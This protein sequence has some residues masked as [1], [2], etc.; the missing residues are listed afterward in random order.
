MRVIRD[1][2]L[3]FNYILRVD[4]FPD[5]RIRL[6]LAARPT[7]AGFLRLR[8]DRDYVSCLHSGLRIGPGRAGYANAM[9]HSPTPQTTQRPIVREIDVAAFPRARLKLQ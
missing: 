7:S 1:C 4:I 5:L 9:S 3:R 2:V 8:H 6:P